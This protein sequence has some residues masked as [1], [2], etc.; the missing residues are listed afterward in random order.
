MTVFCV[1]Q[2]SLLQSVI[3]NIVGSED[4]YERQMQRKKLESDLGV[5]YERLEDLVEGEGDDND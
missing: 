1:V 5:T 3:Q 4:E 2:K